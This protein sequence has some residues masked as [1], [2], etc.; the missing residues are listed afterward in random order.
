MGNHK[1][2]QKSPMGPCKCQAALALKL[3]FQETVRKNLQFDENR[4]QHKF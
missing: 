4:I 2:A 1:R 3:S